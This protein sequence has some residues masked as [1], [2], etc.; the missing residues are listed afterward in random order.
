[1]LRFKLIF[2]EYALGVLFS[3]ALGVFVLLRSHS[4][5]GVALGIYLICLGVNYVPMFAYV[6]SI[7]DK[8]NAQTELGDELL[9]K[10][11]AMAK[12]RRLSL[13]LL[14][15]LLVPVLVVTRER[16]GPPKQRPQ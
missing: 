11:E 3:L 10:R 6:V 13:L 2:A 15:P 14:V 4:V 7:G 5:W 16:V 1:L 8:P 9:E 12:Y